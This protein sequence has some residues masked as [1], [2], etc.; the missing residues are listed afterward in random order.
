[1]RK[2]LLAVLAGV[3][4]VTGPAT[5]GQL[6]QVINGHGPTLHPEGVAWDPARQEFLVGSYL[7]GDISIVRPDG[8]TR[9]LVHDPAVTATFGVHVDAVRNRV[10]A[11]TS[12]GVGIFDL[13]T[14]RTLHLVKA[15]V[16]PNDLAIDWFGNAYVT[17][18]GSDTIFRV[19]VAGNVAPQVKD[20][21]LADPT[22]GLNGIVWHPAGYLLAVRYLDG[23][24]LRIELRDN[25][26]TEVRLPRP[27]IGGDGLALRPDGS[28]IVVTNKLGAPGGEDAVTVLQP[29]ARW[30]AARVTQHKAWPITAPTT[31]AV[32][33]YGSYVLNGRLDWLISD[34]RT[35]DEFFLTRT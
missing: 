11:V 23:R 27:I 19:D 1:M 30:T 2:L 5:A 26:I 22:F 8:R 33:P 24:L 18:P 4:L 17:D 31:V 20:P 7:H 13:R 28:L 9:T 12:D 32:T 6:P 34:G 29:A 21:R 3:L 15:G 25:S 10:L 35:S 14:G 16:R